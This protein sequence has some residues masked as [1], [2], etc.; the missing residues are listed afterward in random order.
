MAFPSRPRR[1][2][3]A[4]VLIASALLSGCASRTRFDGTHVRKEQVDYQVGSLPAGWRRVHVK[5]NDLAFHRSASGT[6]S[7]NARCKGYDDV[8][9]QV[10]LNQLLFG[11]TDRRYLLDEEV[12][13]DGRGALHA[14]TEAELDGVPVRLENYLLL[15]SGCLF[16]L[17]YI[18]NLSAPAADD[19][20]YFV[21]RFHVEAVR[22]D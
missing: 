17:G 2:L 10:L 4:S 20:H 7:V 12:T 21:E 8:P 3:L 18:S 19:F 15:R 13:L 11:T 14:V 16:D 6:I 1:R 22:H 5:G 9:P